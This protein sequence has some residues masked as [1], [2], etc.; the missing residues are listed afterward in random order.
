M[1]LGMMGRGRC[2]ETFETV[3]VDDIKIDRQVL[4]EEN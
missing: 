1:N 2:D 4:S 3:R